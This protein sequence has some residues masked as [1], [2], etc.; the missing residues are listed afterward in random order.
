MFSLAKSGFAIR[1]ETRWVLWGEPNHVTQQ[2]LKK[3][4]FILLIFLKIFY[5]DRKQS[6][7]TQRFPF[8]TVFV[9]CCSLRSHCPA[10]M[11]YAFRITYKRCIEREREYNGA[12]LFVRQGIAAERKRLNSNRCTNKRKHDS[13]PH[14]L[15]N[16]RGQVGICQRGIGRKLHTKWH[17]KTKEG[18]V[19][20][21]QNAHALSDISVALL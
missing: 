5:P 6:E 1:L 15:C 14:F 17:D 21:A 4:W 3:F 18:A 19:K 9:R 13:F 20:M 16:T 12:Q 10:Y 11:F 7:D 8:F 2:Q